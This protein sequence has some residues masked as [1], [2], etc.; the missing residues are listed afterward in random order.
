MSS[1]IF[2]SCALLAPPPGR[3]VSH[4]THA[5]ATAS[6]SSVQ[7]PQAHIPPKDNAGVGPADPGAGA[8]AGAGAGADAGAGAAAITLSTTVS[9]DPTTDDSG[10]PETSHCFGGK[11]TSMS[12]LAPAQPSCSLAATKNDS[13]DAAPS[14]LPVA[15]PLG[16]RR[17]RRSILG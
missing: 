14:K 8:A 3:G 15:V 10:A 1:A 6:F 17:R 11:P 16:P 5:E 12:I 7:A 13:I 9:P 2:C 4:A